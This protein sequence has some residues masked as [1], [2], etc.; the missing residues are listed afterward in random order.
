MFHK[1]YHAKSQESRIATYK[2]MLDDQ[3]IK[4]ALNKLKIIPKDLINTLKFIYFDFNQLDM[5]KAIYN[6]GFNKKNSKRRWPRS[7]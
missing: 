2:L 4:K 6:L 5:E 1:F 3:N 7:I